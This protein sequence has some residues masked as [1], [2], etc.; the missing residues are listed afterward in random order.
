MERSCYQ[1][2]YFKENIILHSEEKYFQKGTWGFEKEWKITKVKC[3][4][5]GK[6]F[7]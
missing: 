7:A 5:N 4:Y 3:T 1:Q 2:I 6:Y